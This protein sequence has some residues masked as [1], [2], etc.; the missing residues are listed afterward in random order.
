MENSQVLF[1]SR[2]LDFWKQFKKNKSAVL[3]LVIISLFIILALFPKQIATFDYAKVDL[4]N[5]F[6]TP[7]NVNYFGTDEFG[8]DLFS[9]V[10]YGARIS[11]L[12]GLGSTLIS[13]VIGVVLG[14]LS[15]YYGK[16]ID[17]ILMRLMD[18]ILAIPQL[19]LA[20]AISAALGNGMRNLMLAVSLA[21]IPRYARITRASV[22]SEKEKEYIE[23][24]RVTGASD[25]KIIVKHILPNCMGPLIV[26]STLGVGT[27]ILSA[28]SL[29]F[30]GMGIQPPEPEW[31]SMLS[32]GRA[33]IRDYPH[34]T[35]FPGLAIAITIFAL[36][37]L[38]DGLRDAFDPKQRR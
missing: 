8:R 23:A 16:T 33:Y 5:Q 25:L 32:T 1:D 11:L 17:N 29:S 24:A 20:I 37:V 15:G 28:A 4:V 7:N 13:L 2:L 21:S 10:V 18:I 27:S 34:V 22:L 31:G 36:N 38:G 14:S 35:L 19:V 12:I 6:K 3:G 9:R 30:I 26:Q